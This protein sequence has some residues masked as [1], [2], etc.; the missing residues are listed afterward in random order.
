MGFER[1]HS[2]AFNQPDTAGFVKFAV[3]DMPQQPANYQHI[4]HTNR[5]GPALLGEI[6][7]QPLTI[8]QSIAIFQ[9]GAALIDLRSQHEYVEKHI[10]GSV[11]ADWSP[12]FS[13]RVSQVLPPQAPI[14]LLLGQNAAYREVFYALARVGYEQVMGFLNEDMESWERMGL[15]VA[16]GDI[17]DITPD[18]LNELIEEDQVKVVDVREP[19]EARYMRIAESLLIPLGQLSARIAELDPGQPTAVICQHGSRSQAGAAILGQ[20]GFKKVYNVM[21]GMSAWVLRGL[22]VKRG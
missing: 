3:Q 16:S 10:P 2:P 15:P 21:G 13:S 18:Q 17:E 9:Q 8:Q 4:K 22:P 7:P 12:Q 20:S 5:R 11:H 1:Q 19:F 6:R 14:V